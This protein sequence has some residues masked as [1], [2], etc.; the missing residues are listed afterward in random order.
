MIPAD[1]MIP[2]IKSGLVRFGLFAHANQLASRNQGLSPVLDLGQWW[3]KQGDKQGQPLPLHLAAI[4]KTLPDE[5]AQRL[6][7]L[8]SQSVQYAMD[9]RSEAITAASLYAP[10][11][12]LDQMEP[13]IEQ[14]ITNLCLDMGPAGSAAIE[15]LLLRGHNQGLFD[16]PQPIEFC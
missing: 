16:N 15:E 9:N 11:E 6:S 3:S 12:Q 5:I 4:K 14:Y 10:Y 1:K 7:G 2:A 13:F 8:I